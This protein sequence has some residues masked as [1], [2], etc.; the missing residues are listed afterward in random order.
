[1]LAHLPGYASE[2]AGVAGH[3]LRRDDG[4]VVAVSESNLTDPVAVVAEDRELCPF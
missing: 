1:L 2:S 3:Y 4:F